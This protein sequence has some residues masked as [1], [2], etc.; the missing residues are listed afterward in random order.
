MIHNLIRKIRAWFVDKPNRVLQWNVEDFRW[1]RRWA[2]TQPDPLGERSSL[3]AR[4]Y[5]P[6]RD[7]VE[8]LDEINRIVNGEHE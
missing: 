6:R 5:S 1:A 4:I 8:I 7:S 2:L 3:W